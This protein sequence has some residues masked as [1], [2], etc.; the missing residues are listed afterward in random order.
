MIGR[1]LPAAALAAA[2]EAVPS[3]VAQRATTPATAKKAR[4]EVIPRLQSMLDG[5]HSERMGSDGRGVHG[6]VSEA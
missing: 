3:E 1:V 2:G 5:G 6:D 4:G